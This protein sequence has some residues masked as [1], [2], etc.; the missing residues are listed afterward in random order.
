MGSFKH[1]LSGSM[2][3]KTL[4]GSREHLL[5]LIG[6][7]QTTSFAWT[8]ERHTSMNRVSDQTHKLI[9]EE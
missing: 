2:V 6:R 5:S 8:C 3:A 7:S 1:M 4:C 9:A